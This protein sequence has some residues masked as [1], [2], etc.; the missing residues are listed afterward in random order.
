MADQLD[1]TVVRKLVQIDT[2]GDP[3][4]LLLVTYLGAAF[5]ASL[6]GGVR[7][8]M[9]PHQEK[10]RELLNG[11]P[12]NAHLRPPDLGLVNNVSRQLE[13]VYRIAVF[14]SFLNNLTSYALAARPAK[15]IGRAQM[16]VSILLGKARAEVVNE[17]IAR[18]TKF[19]SRENFGTRFQ[20][21]RKITDAD[22]QIPK[23][24]LDHLKR[25]SNLR[26]AIIHEGS[27]F[28]FTVDDQLRIH[29]EAQTQAVAMRNENFGVVNRVAALL[30]E[31][32]VIKFIQRPLNHVE[33]NMITALNPSLEPK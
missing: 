9:V 25:L 4:L 33:H 12:S 23:A 19:L 7:A 31:Q 13:L 17:Y 5:H 8:F 18:R 24:D 28:Q 14:D 30:Y 1:S 20:A 16:Q 29:S 22:I 3:L 27:A 26:N 10:I 6:F 32:Y 2:G 15:A 21:L 11:P